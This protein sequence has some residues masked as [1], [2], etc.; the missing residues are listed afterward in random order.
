MCCF[1]GPMTHAGVIIT[2]YKMVHDGETAYQSINNKRPSDNILPVG[3]KIV[4]VMAEDNQLESAHRFE[5]F[6]GTVRRT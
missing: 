6:A 2:R 4:W 3:E 5:M 1:R